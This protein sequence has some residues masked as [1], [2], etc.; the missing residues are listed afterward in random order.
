MKLR[1]LSFTAAYFAIHDLHLLYDC[2]VLFWSRSWLVLHS[3]WWKWISFSAEGTSVIGVLRVIL[4]FE[5]CFCLCWQSALWRGHY[6]WSEDFLI[7]LHQSP[8]SSFWR[9]ET[10]VRR[11]FRSSWHWG[12]LWRSPESGADW[13]ALSSWLPCSNIFRS[14]LGVLF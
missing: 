5:S 9:T 13:P 7:L 3:R 11:G 4:S 14:Y 10:S 1:A 2:F 6:L 12:C 8:S